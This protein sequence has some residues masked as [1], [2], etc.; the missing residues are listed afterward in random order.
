MLDRPPIA[1][2][3]LAAV[4]DRRRAVLQA[5]VVSDQRA[6]DGENREGRPQR[7]MQDYQEEQRDG[8]PTSIH[9]VLCS[10][11]QVHQPGS[12]MEKT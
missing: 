10:L 1:A 4:L 11:F 8:T 7:F 12:Q 3:M 5:L 9:N 2:G 6:R